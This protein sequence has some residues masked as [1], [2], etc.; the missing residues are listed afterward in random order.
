VDDR[1]ETNVDTRVSAVDHVL[2]KGWNRH[3]RVAVEEAY[4]G[5]DGGKDVY[6]TT[7]ERMRDFD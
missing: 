6:G 2:P 7:P 5:R 4:L 3:G 1:G